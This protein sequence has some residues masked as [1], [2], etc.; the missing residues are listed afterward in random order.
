MSNKNPFEVRLEVLEMA[1]TFL[2]RQYDDQSNAWWTMV[3]TYSEQYN[4]NLEKAME[5]VMDKKPVMFT[6]ADVIKKAEELYT[7][8]TKKE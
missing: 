8:V 3:N 4:E 2:D 1:R 7:F 6:P 5:M